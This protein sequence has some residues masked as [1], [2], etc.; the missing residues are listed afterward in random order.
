MLSRI[1]VQLTL[2][3]ICKALSD[4]DVEVRYMCSDGD[5]S[6]NKR[7]YDFFMKWYP[8]LLQAGLM[9]ALEVVANETMIPVSGFLDFLKNFCNKV[10]NQSVTICPELHE[11]IL[12][13][14]NL[15]SLLR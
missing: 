2:D 3:K 9:T 7:H 6:Y 10:K 14:Q 11:D 8:V 5:S 13:C 4:R 1:K 12:T 15:E